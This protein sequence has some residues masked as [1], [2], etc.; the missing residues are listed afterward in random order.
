MNHRIVI[1]HGDVL[2]SYLALLR[3]AMERSGFVVEHV[4]PPWSHTP[5]ITWIHWPEA[6]FGWREPERAEVARFEE[7]IRRCAGRGLVLWTVHNAFPHAW[8]RSRRYR[9]VYR[10]VAESAQIH[11]HHGTSSIREIEKRY[12]S[13]HPLITRTYPHGGYWQLI[14][15]LT[16][17]AARDQLGLTGRGR[18]LLVFGEVRGPRELRLVFHATRARGWHVLLVGRLRARRK[19]LWLLMNLLTRLV[20]TKRWRL[21]TGSVPDE[22]VDA[23]VKAADAVFIPR[24][25]VLNSGNVFLGFTFGKPVIGPN[26]GNVG[27]V[28]SLTRNPTFDPK[29]A[30]SIARALA[31][32]SS[33]DMASL[34][35]RNAAWLQQ[36]GQW[37]QAAAAARQ[38]VEEGIRLRSRDAPVDRDGSA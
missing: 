11:L 25:E 19:S 29:D 14:G 32:L 26:V 10:L 12:P 8:G 16:P 28:L 24:Y 31:A 9:D 2:N 35:R 5:D 37:D 7:W 17:E 4:D 21:I 1:P 34:G 15:D 20:P 18:I 33:E 3:S 27:E 22:R 30:R 6:M 38:A 23:Y 36:N 13:A